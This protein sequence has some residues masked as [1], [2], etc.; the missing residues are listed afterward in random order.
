MSGW[1]ADLSIVFVT[2]WGADFPAFP[3][4]EDVIVELE[5]GV[6]FGL[7]FEAAD[8]E[9][10]VGSGQTRASWIAASS[11]RPVRRYM[12]LPSDSLSQ[13]GCWSER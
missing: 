10:V 5:T 6:G 11:S 13:R 4:R 9:V 8:L 2:G 12:R 3:L 7:S 1:R